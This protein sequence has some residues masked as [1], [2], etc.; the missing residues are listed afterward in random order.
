M[1][2]R[3]VLPLLASHVFVTLA[4][5]RDPFAVNRAQLAEMQAAA[6]FS[7]LDEALQLLK[8]G[9]TQ[10]LCYALAMERQEG[11]PSKPS[12][13]H[14]V[15]CRPAEFGA[16]NAF[17]RGAGTNTIAAVEPADA[18]GS[19][20]DIRCH[21]HG[22]TVPCAGNILLAVRGGC[23]F[24]H[25]YLNLLQASEG[26]AKAIWISDSAPERG[27]RPLMKLMRGQDAVDPLETAHKDVPV[28]SVSASD[29][30]WLLG[31]VSGTSHSLMTGMEFS[32][33]AGEHSWRHK[34]KEHDVA[35]RLFRAPAG[36]RLWAALADAVAAQGERRADEARAYRTL[37]AALKQRRKRAKQEEL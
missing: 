34:V 4:G 17:K 15:A 10:Q 31:L 27:P 12:R 26:G 21:A 30:Q 25:K 13:Q 16:A 24:Y 29:G 37:S 8:R 9:H 23:G 14:N 20:A 19:A 35:Q 6:G 7:S 5:T 2:A 22:K 36:P 18:C 33:H 32:E 1:R 3:F 28:A 11:K